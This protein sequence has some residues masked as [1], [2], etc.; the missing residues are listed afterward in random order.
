MQV[1]LADGSV[2]SL[3]PTMSGA[4]WWAA[5]TPSGGDVLG[6]GLVRGRAGPNRF[7]LLTIDSPPATLR[8]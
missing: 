8:G 1:C 2:R 7:S 5:C 3:A 4:T 6:S